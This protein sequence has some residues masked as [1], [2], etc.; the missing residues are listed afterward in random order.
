MKLKLFPSHISEGWIVWDEEQGVSCHHSAPNWPDDGRDKMSIY[1]GMGGENPGTT[2]GLSQHFLLITLNRKEVERLLQ[3]VNLAHVKYHYPKDLKEKPAKMKPLFSPPRNLEMMKIDN[4]TIFPKPSYLYYDFWKFFADKFCKGR[5]VTWTFCVPPCGKNKGDHIVDY[6]EVIDFDGMGNGF[7][8]FP[9][10]A[11]HMKL[12]RCLKK[13]TVGISGW[14]HS[15]S[16]IPRGSL[17]IAID[18]E[19]L[20]ESFAMLFKT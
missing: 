19:K 3:F 5:V 12:G 8:S 1:K 10:K 18:S 7:G 16:Q 6:K 11:N 17:F 14:N 2:T 20:H 9:W 13:K 15:H 4:L